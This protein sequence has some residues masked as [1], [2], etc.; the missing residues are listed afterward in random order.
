MCFIFVNSLMKNKQ[1]IV[2]VVCHDAGGAEIVSS[3]ISL[4]DITAKYCLSGP[5]IKVFERKFG[6][7]KNSSL[8]DMI[9]DVDWLLC[10]TS[11]QSSLEWNAIQKAKKQGKK[12]ISFLDH[13][14]NYPERF[15]RNDVIALPNE[16]W[17][18]DIY[19]QEIAERCFPN[20][21]IEF[22]HKIE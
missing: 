13:W 7:I 16:I 2:G 14:T 21:K 1:K 12:I 15:N 8:V 19:A 22:I 10:G 17:V 3:Y 4:N 6:T 5:A 11:W 18:G 9:D 20:I